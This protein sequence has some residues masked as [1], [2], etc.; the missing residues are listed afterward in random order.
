MSGVPRNVAKRGRGVRTRCDAGQGHCCQR[1]R[2]FRR[3]R[4]PHVQSGTRREKPNSRAARMGLRSCYQ[5]SD[6]RTVELF[7][8][9]HRYNLHRPHGSL[10]A[11]TPIGRLGLSEDNLSRLH[12]WYKL[13]PLF[14]ARTAMR[15]TKSSG[16]SAAKNRRTGTSMHYLQWTA[17]R[18]RRVVCFE[19]LS[20]AEREKPSK[21]ASCTQKRA[22]ACWPGQSV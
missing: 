14:V 8:W 4:R 15:C 12:S 11:K 7:N 20:V 9:L 2:S 17:C 3:R 1:R 18:P 13:P 22:G 16:R 21:T 19:I 10:K 5:N 6:Q